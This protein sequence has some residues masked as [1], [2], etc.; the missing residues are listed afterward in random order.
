MCFISLCLIRMRYV[1]LGN[2]PLLSEISFIL[3]Q[4]STSLL[5]MPNSSS[6]SLSA[7]STASASPASALPPGKLTSRPCFLSPADRFV[8]KRQTSPSLTHSGMST[9]APLSW[10]LFSLGDFLIGLK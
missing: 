7:V 3:P 2:I 4:T 9:A 5:A 10:T 1:D 8:Y 6:V